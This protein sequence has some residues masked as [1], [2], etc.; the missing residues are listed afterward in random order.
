[1]EKMLTSNLT[2]ILME[3]RASYH[4]VIVRIQTT[5]YENTSSLHVTSSSQ[6][7]FVD[8]PFFVRVEVMRS[9]SVQTGYFYVYHET[10]HFKKVLIYSSRV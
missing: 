7:S 6:K 9:N 5:K 1:M 2:Y 4:F 10:V 3:F 8:N